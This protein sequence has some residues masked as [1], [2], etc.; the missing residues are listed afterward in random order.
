MVTETLAPEPVLHLVKCKC[1]KTQYTT[2][3][4]S[5]KNAGLYCT[6]PCMC[7]EQDDDEC[8][9][10]DQGRILEENDDEEMK[11]IKMK[12]IMTNLEQF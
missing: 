1:A 5:C 6:D 11:D 9:N 3:Q 4:C 10:A 2:M 7:C 8:D 12:F